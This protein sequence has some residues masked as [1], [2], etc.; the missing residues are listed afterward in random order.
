[1][2]QQELQRS[3]SG[4]A[5]GSRDES[6]CVFDS[7]DELIDVEWISG[8]RPFQD[9]WTLQHV[10]NSSPRQERER[11][12]HHRHSQPGTQQESFVPERQSRE[13]QKSPHGARALGKQRFRQSLA[14]TPAVQH[15]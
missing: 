14:Q 7:P 6:T 8:R 1:M 10:L 15:R 2:S 13:R 9:A 11:Q 3:R 5:P 12:V 4:Q